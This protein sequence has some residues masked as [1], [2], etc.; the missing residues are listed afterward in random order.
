MK[1]KLI[2]ILANIL[3]FFR[4]FLTVIR[5]HAF[6]TTSHRRHLIAYN[7]YEI[8]EMEKCY[9]HFKKYFPA[10]IFLEKNIQEYS[11]KKAKGCDVEDSG[12]YIEFGVFK[13]TT[14]NILSKFVKKIYGFDS[15]EGLKDDWNGFQNHPKGTFDLKKKLPKLNKNVT[16]VVGW[17]QDTLEPFLKESDQ[18]IIFVHLDLDTFESTKFVLLK[19]KPRLVKGSVI[20]FDQLYNYPGWR[21]GEYKAM[22]EVFNENEYRFLMFSKIGEQAAIEIL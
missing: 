6:P 22:T 9:Q 7:K 16:T 12:L 20:L 4:Y 2:Q 3:H 14:I 19:I 1:S 21:G 11:I 18:K 10:A 5:N 17:V 13:G 8:E 15:F